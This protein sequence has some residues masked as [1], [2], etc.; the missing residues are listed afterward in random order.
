MHYDAHVVARVLLASVTDTLGHFSET[1][2]DKSWFPV[3]YI[4]IYWS[5][6]VEAG[7]IPNVDMTRLCSMQ[8]TEGTR[9]FPF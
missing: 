9:C 2:H 5:K 6:A 4:Y 3:I 1:S 7:K 8:P